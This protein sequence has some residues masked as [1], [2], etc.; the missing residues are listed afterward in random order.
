MQQQREAFLPPWTTGLET[1]TNTRR[2]RSHGTQDSAQH[3]G[4]QTRGSQAHAGGFPHPHPGKPRRKKL[5]AT[6]A[7]LL[8]QVDV[9]KMKIKDLIIQNKLD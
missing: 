2:G 5:V 1:H 8:N 7:E 3:T 9:R 4:T 6:W